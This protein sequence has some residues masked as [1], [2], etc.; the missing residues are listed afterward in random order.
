M[1][2]ASSNLASTSRWINTSNLP[3][4]FCPTFP[5]AYRLGLEL[6]CVA[7]FNCSENTA[8]HNLVYKGVVSALKAYLI[9]FKLGEYNGQFTTFIPFLT[10]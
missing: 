10:H 8:Y 6:C 1:L 5:H 9:G 7:L 3:K 2:P 4:Y